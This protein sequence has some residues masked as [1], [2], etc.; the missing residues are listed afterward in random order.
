MIIN[1]KYLNSKPKYELP[2]DVKVGL[3]DAYYKKEPNFVPNVCINR[4]GTVGIRDY[5]DT[6]VQ[7]CIKTNDIGL[8]KYLESYNWG[9]K[10]SRGNSIVKAG[11]CNK[12]QVE[13]LISEYYANIK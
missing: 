1:N 10:F 12:W 6:S 4:W 7:V 11:K 9:A 5:K 2:N 8:I 3:Y 13:K